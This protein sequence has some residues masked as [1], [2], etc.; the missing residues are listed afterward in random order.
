[1]ACVGTLKNKSFIFNTENNIKSRWLQFIIALSKNNHHLVI[2]SF[3]LDVKWSNEMHMHV[4]HAWC[5]TRDND[6]QIHLLS[7]TVLNYINLKEM[8]DPIYK[9]PISSAI[10]PYI[11]RS[12]FKTTKNT[13]STI[14]CENITFRVKHCNITK[15]MREQ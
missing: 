13:I 14:K 3:N 5:L 12:V 11:N 4:I 2:W 8:C 15:R 7:P 1:M 9:W 10:L 6:T